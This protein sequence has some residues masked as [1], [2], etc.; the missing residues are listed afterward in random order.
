MD[1]V[2]SL[3]TPSAPLGSVYLWRK[4]KDWD[5]ID[6]QPAT[7][8]PAELVNALTMG[9][10]TDPETGSE[11]AQSLAE[12]HDLGASVA[13]IQSGLSIPEQIPAGIYDWIPLPPP[14]K[15]KRG[16]RPS[17]ECRRQIDAFT[18]V[19]TQHQSLK[20]AADEMG[21]TPQN[22]SKLARAWK[23]K[24]EAKPQRSNREPGPMPRGEQV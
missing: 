4:R 11:W 21:C 17:V 16:R 22:V 7:A 13:S 6:R 15:K 2:T 18:K 1:P 3:E 5:P 9:L 12:F 8:S 14:A 23:K 19:Y 10:L 24:V 20:Q